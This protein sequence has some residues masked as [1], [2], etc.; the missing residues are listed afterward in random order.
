MIQLE[1]SEGSL[2]VILAVLQD[3]IEDT[4]YGA[5]YRD[6]MR[7]IYDDIEKSI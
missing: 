6:V 2:S 3:A 5:E 1:L 4:S 7:L